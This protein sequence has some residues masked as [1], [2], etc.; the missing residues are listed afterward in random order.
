MD[1]QFKLCLHGKYAYCPC[2]GADNFPDDQMVRTGAF[3]ELNSKVAYAFNLPKYKNIIELYAGVKNIFNAYQ[4]DF[5]TGKNRDS[6]YIYGPNM[7][8]TYFVGVKIKT[9]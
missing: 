7:P 8:R 3:S 4:T 1:S 9:P 6:N 2:R 5:D